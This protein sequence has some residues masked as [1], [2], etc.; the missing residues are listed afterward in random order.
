VTRFDAP[1]EPM[2]LGNTRELDVRSLDVS[3]WICQHQAVLSAERWLDE[4][5]VPAIGPRM[6]CTG[7]GIVDADARPN[8]KEQPPREMLAGVQWRS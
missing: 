5:T 2:T 3:C 6:A 1:I 8:W 7:C 4:V